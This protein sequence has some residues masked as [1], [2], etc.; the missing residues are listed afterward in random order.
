[1]CT[2]ATREGRK[3]RQTVLLWV[4]DAETRRW[5]E[6]NSKGPGPVSQ[7][8]GQWATF[9]YDPEHNVHLLI[10]CVRRDRGLGVS[11]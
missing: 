3:Y 2:L 11:I 10:N 1:M 8:T 4:L 6:M 7:T 5:R 9:W